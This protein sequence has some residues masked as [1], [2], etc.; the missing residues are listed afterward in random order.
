MSVT[1]IAGITGA[2]T[3]ALA[4]L[5]ASDTNAQPRLGWGFETSGLL[6]VQGDADL[7]GGGDVSATR[8]A[9]RFGGLYT[10]ENG[11]AAGVSLQLGNHGY[12][13]GGGAVPLWGDVRDIGISA[14]IRFSVGSSA[15]VLLAPSV[16]WSYEN[17]ASTSDAVTYGV[18]GGVSW[19]VSDGLRIGP[20]FGAF[21]ELEGSDINL[22]PALIVDW[23]ITDR[24]SLETGAGIGATQGPGVRLSYAYSDAVDLSLGVRYENTEFRLDNTGLA[25]GGLGQDSSIP[26]VLALDYNPNPG[27]SLSAFV[28][29]AF[30]GELTLENAL[31]ATVAKQSYDTAPVAGLSFRLR[32]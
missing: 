26:V 13:F 28:G 21:T 30:E 7:S 22:F 14:P 1:R 19:Q 18:F 15:Q 11:A 3:V 29:A 32:F 5:T 10:F 25:P 16:R 9:L 8:A 6:A 31:G 27:V 20:A 23:Q 4:G 12:D 17:G 2:M 24:V